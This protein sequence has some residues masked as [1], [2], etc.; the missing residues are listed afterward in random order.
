MV[1]KSFCDCHNDL[2]VG[3]RKGFAKKNRSSMTSSPFLDLLPNFMNIY[4][5]TE[6]EL[7]IDKNFCNQI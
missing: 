4:S 6:K 2:N 5:I 3:A 7:L 1:L